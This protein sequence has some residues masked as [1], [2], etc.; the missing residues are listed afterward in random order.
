MK[1]VFF[2]SFFV[3]I[4][5]HI[6]LDRLKIGA[7]SLTAPIALYRNV[8]LK[9]VFL[10]RNLINLC[11]LMKTKFNIKKII[12]TILDFL[13]LE[14]PRFFCRK[15]LLCSKILAILL[16]EVSANC[17]S[18]EDSHNSSFCCLVFTRI[19]AG[20]ST[21]VAAWAG[22][23]Q[24]IVASSSGLFRALHKY[25]LYVMSLNFNLGFFRAWLMNNQ[26][27]LDQTKDKAH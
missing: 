12:L 24:L 25:I 5:K 23:S 8:W 19:S 18:F 13:I 10:M 15:F 26:L 1:L 14:V 11:P 9:Q 20:P 6:N 22:S 16:F 4:V 2:Y 3:P 17:S 27:H 21:A 7:L